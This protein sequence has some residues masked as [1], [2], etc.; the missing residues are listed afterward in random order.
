M[1]IVT[2][3]VEILFSSYDLEKVQDLAQDPQPIKQQVQGPY[4]RLATAEVSRS[5]L[6][7][8]LPSEGPLCFPWHLAGCLAYAGY[9]VHAFFF[10]F[11]F[12][13]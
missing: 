2:H 6:W 5:S 7:A 9:S 8:V 11:F 10:F 4:S 13:F 1:A 3:E 12:F